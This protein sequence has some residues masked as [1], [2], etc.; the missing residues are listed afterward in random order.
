MQR[1][2]EE[3]PVLLIVATI[4]GAAW[5]AAWNVQGFIAAQVAASEARLTAQIVET[6]EQIAETREQVAETREQIAEIRKYLVDHLGDHGAA[7]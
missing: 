4:A 1:L 7:D 3:W 6:R 2:R 5:M